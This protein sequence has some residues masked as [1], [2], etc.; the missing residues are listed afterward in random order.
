M[1]S[2]LAGP[3][4]IDFLRRHS[5]GQNI[6]EEGPEHHSVKQ[7]TPTMGGVL[8]VIAASIAF[9]ATTV[10]T[11]PAL[12]IWGTMLACGGIGFL[13]DLIKVR[14]KRSLGLSGRIKMLL[15]LAISAVVCIA[16][17]HQGICAPRVHPDRPAVHPARLRL[18]RARLR[19][20]RRLGER[21]EPHRRPR[22][23][24]R[25]DVDHL[26]LHAHGD[27]RHD[28]HPQHRPDHPHADR[29]PARRRLHRR[30]DD[31]RGR[32]LPLVQRVPGRGVHGRH[33]RDGARRRDRR[34]WRSSCRCRCSCSSSAASS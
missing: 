32:R 23:A 19:D 14:H 7:G 20:H 16:A 21:G 28:L 9:L 6:R 33:G 5:L 3:F 18:V 29:E 4:F 30:R 31:R 25:R 11:V 22:R 26:A 10:R 24:R 15:L 8:I 2:I 1:I 27:G 13:D 34:R 17:D 12:T